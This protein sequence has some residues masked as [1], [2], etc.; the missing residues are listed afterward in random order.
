MTQRASI[1]ALQRTRQFFV[2][3]AAVEQHGDSTP[4]QNDLN[5]DLEITWSLHSPFTHADFVAEPSLCALS[6]KGVMKNK[7][8][9]AAA[10]ARGGRTDKKNRKPEGASRR[11]AASGAAKDAQAEDTGAQA[12]SERIAKRLAR[13]GIASR[14]DAEA[15]IAEGRVKVNGKVLD[16]PAFNVSPRDRVEV[17]DAPLPEVERTRLFLFHKPA[18]VVTTTRDPEGRPTIF[19]VLP[20]GLPRLIS[21]G[22]L[23]INTEGLLLLTNDGGLSRVLELPSTGWLRRYRVRVHGQVDQAQLDELQKGI[24]V[25]GVFY[26]SIEATLDRVQGANSWLTVSFR[27]GKNRE[28][29]NVLGALGLQVTRLIRVSFGPFQLGDLPEGAVQEVKG[30]MLRDQ[31]GPRLVEASG[32]D[33]EAPIAIPFSNRPVRAGEEREEDL[34]DDKKE[35]APKGRAPTT[36]KKTR[37]EYREEGRERLQTKAPRREDGKPARGARPGRPERDGEGRPPRAAAGDRPARGRF[38]RDGEGRPQ[39]AAAG[40]RPARGRFERD[41]EGRPQRAAAGDRPAKGRFERSEGREERRFDKPRVN[42]V[43]VLSA[44]HVPKVVSRVFVVRVQYRVSASLA[45]AAKSAASLAHVVRM[46]VTARSVD[47]VLKVRSGHRAVRG[48]CRAN[49]L[50]ASA[51]RA[52]ALSARKVATSHSAAVG[53]RMVVVIVVLAATAPQRAVN[54]AVSARATR[55]RDV[56]AA[57]VATGRTTTDVRVPLMSGWRR[58]LVRSP[59]SPRKSRNAR[60]QSVGPSGPATAHRA[61]GVTRDVAALAASRAA[62][63][64]A[65]GPASHV[66][67][68]SGNRLCGLLA[69]R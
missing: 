54:A 5:P 46:A 1:A 68:A 28:V 62:I 58:V 43:R 10:P 39:R 19:E 6:G 16:T 41:G 59:R 36:R 44:Q 4:T 55:A 42:A 18:G 25:D 56:P 31:L 47:H 15:M 27:E 65:T 11:T 60:V 64:P 51:A 32:A 30:R 63:V 38:E 66:L 61:G 34:T 23:D 20:K 29:K 53:P 7:R 35:R 9:S 57:R 50:A 2:F 37:E 26:G 69:V 52:R 33:F 49:V 14:R 67:R 48:R 21:V 8:P 17:D 22:R 13:A 40:E 3:A 12:G 45:K 24:A